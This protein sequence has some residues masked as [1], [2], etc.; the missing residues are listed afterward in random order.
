[1]SLVYCL[2]DD[3]GIRE[4]ILC[5]L[6]S[7]G[8]EVMGFATA[9]D[10]KVAMKSKLPNI[11]L[12]DVMIPDEDGFSIL[13]S[14]KK[15]TNTLDIPV[16]MLTAKSSEI[17]K[18]NG[19]E[20]GA[21]DYITKPFGIMELLSRIK[22]VLRRSNKPL[23]VETSA[24]NVNGLIVDTEKRT[25]MFNDHEI[26]LTFKEF[27]ILVYLLKNRGIAVSRDK[28]MSKVWGF[29]YEGESRTVDVHIKTLRQK[30]EAQ[31]CENPIITIRGF[32]YKIK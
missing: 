15:N 3:D 22:A 18:V 9:N 29:E 14:L 27:E 12:L 32:G 25:V 28:L 7:G 23:T 30:L 24:Y 31:G 2:E 4:L 20:L 6:K 8:Y 11:V 17:D 16:I 5:A 13:K 1:M 19:L 10:F 26:T 21:D